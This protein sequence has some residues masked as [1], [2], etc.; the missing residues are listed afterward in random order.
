MKIYFAPLEGITGYVYRNTYHNFFSEADKYFLPF[1]VPHTKRDFNTKEKNDIL[2][3]HNKGMNSIPQ[4]LTKKPEDFLTLA[5]ELKELGYSEININAGCPSGTVVGKNRGAGLL[6]DSYVLNSFLDDIFSKVDVKVS[7]KTRIGMEEPEEFY[8]LLKVYNKFPIHELIIHS[9]VRNDFYNNTPNW[10]IYEYAVEHSNNPVVYNGDI[11]DLE[12]FHAFKDRF[13]KENTVMIGR[14]IL[15]N[16]GLIGEIHGMK[17][18]HKDRLKEFH[19]ELIL[20]YKNCLGS[21]NNVMFKMK[22]VWSYM[23]NSFVNADSYLKKI[24]KAKHFEEY[25]I[26]TNELFHTCSLK[27]NHI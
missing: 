1:I 18:I 14:G 4:V 11:K 24:Q 10:D 2:P 25:Q 20:E 22:E 19:D 5:Q 13:P 17:P 23:G 16:P 12:S 9:R 6:K 7:V 27:S 8:D 15:T 3:A 26:W 21:D